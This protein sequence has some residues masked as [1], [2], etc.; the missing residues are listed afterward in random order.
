MNTALIGALIGCIIGLAGGII[1][2]YF[3]IRNTKGPRE[4][5]FMIKASVVGWIVIGVFLAMLL[6]LPSPYR[7]FMWIPY[8]IL[9]P[10][11]IIFLNKRL[12]Q[13][14]AEESKP[15]L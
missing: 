4:R 12:A 15:A 9:L 7:W 5:T 1:G 2:T 13:I 3:S 6:L 14:R 11:G 10:F 8:G